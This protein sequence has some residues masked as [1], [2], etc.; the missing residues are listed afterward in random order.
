[1]PRLGIS[2]NQCLGYVHSF[3]YRNC[4]YNTPAKTLEI[5]L[6]K[7][8]IEIEWIINLMKNKFKLHRL[9]LCS[10]SMINSLTQL[11]W[12][13]RVHTQPQTWPNFYSGRYISII[14]IMIIIFFFNKKP[15]T[16]SSVLTKFARY[17]F[18]LMSSSST[19]NQQ[20]QWKKKL[21]IFIVHL[22]LYIVYFTITSLL[23]FD[24]V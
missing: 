19:N 21:T 6:P 22:L 11:L 4:L 1:M 5:L 20:F 3:V 7:Q 18:G 2:N 12:R 24:N 23:A 9:T 8:I 16:L 14:M 13:R 10:E 17:S 15:L